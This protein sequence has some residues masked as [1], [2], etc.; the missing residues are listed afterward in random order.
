VTRMSRRPR[1]HAPGIARPR[2]R[3]CP[4]AANCHRPTSRVPGS[5]RRAGFQIDAAQQEP[6]ALTGGNDDQQP[7]VRNE[8]EATLEQLGLAVQAVRDRDTTPSIDCEHGDVRPVSEHLDDDWC[9]PPRARTVGPTRGDIIVPL[10]RGQEPWTA[11]PA[12][13]AGTKRPVVWRK[14]LT[15][16][17]EYSPVRGGDDQ[18][19]P[20]AFPVLCNLDAVNGVHLRTP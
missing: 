9:S 13:L 20:R 7:G 17:V 14:Q 15:W 19:R 10:H 16:G 18:V 6:V 1:G 4:V 12:A 8:N 2:P 11:G 3:W 5:F